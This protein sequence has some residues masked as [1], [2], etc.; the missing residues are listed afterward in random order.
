MAL[1]ESPSKYAVVTTGPA[2]P[3]QRLPVVLCILFVL[4]GSS[5]L[6]YEIVWLRMLGRTLGSTV[7]AASV[8]L[9]V[10]MGGLA[11]GS[12][13]FGRFADRVKRPLA[14]YACIEAGI[15][16][17]A[18]LSLGLN[19][20][21][22]AFY[23]AIY[24]MAGESRAAL[25]VGQ[26]VLV[27]IALLIPTSLMGGTL[28]TLCAYGVRRVGSIGRMVGILYALNTLGALAGV[29]AAGYVLI[30]I[31]GETRTVLIGFAINCFVAFV[32]LF[33]LPSGSVRVP[34]D[35][36]ANDSTAAETPLMPSAR[37]PSSDRVR[38]AVLVC[39]ALSGFVS[40]GLEIV[41][42]RML[43]LYEGTSIYAFSA[44]LAVML[45]GIGI[46]GMLGAKVE[47]WKDPL[48]ALARL[49]MG[50]AIA[51]ALSMIVFRYLI[52]GRFWPAVIVV[53]PTALFLGIAFPVA[54]RCYA[55]QA[56]AIGRRVG[57]LYAWNTVGC[58]LGALAGGFLLIPI[59]GAGPS[60]AIL[61]GITLLVSIAL[62][63]VH[64]KGLF[65]IRLADV[66]GL[67]AAGTMLAV[68][69]DP[70]RDVIF[71]RFKP[72]W[73][74]FGHVEEAAATTTAA[75]IP[76]VRLSREL[77]VNGYGMTILITGNKLMAHLPIWMAD[78]PHDAL[79]ICMG[80][81]TTFR[82]AVRHPDID[83]TV[84]ELDPA[85]PKF[86]H[87]Y[88]ADADRVL[89]QPNAH[90]VVD[91]GRNYLLMHQHQFDAIT[92]DPPPPLYGAGTVNL[93]SKEFF[94]L[95]AARIRPT[96]AVC[97]WVPPG[98]RSDEMMILHTYAEVFPY[99]AVW[100]G[101]TFPGFLLI[102]THR[103]VNDIEA[104][105]RRGFTDPATVADLTEWDDSCSTPEKVMSLL[106]CNRDAL[107]QFSKNSPVITDDRPYTEFPIWRMAGWDPEYAEVLNTDIFRV[108]LKS[109]G[110]K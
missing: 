23:R 64:P 60:G 54:V 19:S 17:T 2:G 10:F 93:Y 8:I 29:L 81:G 78:S 48:R 94:E 98:A 74:V 34:E 49:E 15:G 99:V 77:L 67:L 101:P 103:P 31:I 86:M 70:Y 46:G 1:T 83:T 108:W 27:T 21:P 26:I 22:L 84:V 79:V 53:G 42:S 43:I 87:F 57:E 76:N 110:G 73:E 56:R 30:G 16:V 80:M 107:L 55:D 6:M 45:A 52:Y 4:S 39:F 104:R 68:I 18:L 66:A 106:I 25:T 24:S 41:W 97:L 82:S 36:M 72:G 3:S 33:F 20:W 7:Y 92:L 95:C 11:L 59:F 40:L 9:A 105:V 91:D 69:G 32:A 51:V 38:R 50:A 61:G 44:M 109:D 5:G 96:G 85:V 100:A 88:H 47:K 28:P 58:I 71:S 14:L 37:Q 13:I 35:S 65:R 12:F 62:F 102:G 89:A 90:V 63:A 75:G